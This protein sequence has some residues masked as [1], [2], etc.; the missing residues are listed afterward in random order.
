MGK[1]MCIKITFT[2]ITKHFN[3]IDLTIITKHFNVIDFNVK[4]GQRI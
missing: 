2:I 1:L 3:V 4:W